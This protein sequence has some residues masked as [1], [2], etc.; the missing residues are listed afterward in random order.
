VAT[1]TSAE[2]IDQYLKP[3]PAGQ[4]A[5][6]QKLRKAIHAAAPGAEECI[7]Y[8]VPAFRLGGKLFVAFGVARHHCSFYPGAYPVKALED[9][10]EGYDTSKGTVRFPA[11]RPL[12]AAL[13][14]KLV[15]ARLSRRDAEP[16]AGKGAA[17]RRKR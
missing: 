4:R 1:K 7:S 13:V 2:T 6:L 10:L 14:K 17:R 11:E 15:R 3:L 16:A 12:P 5:A 8:G 9:D